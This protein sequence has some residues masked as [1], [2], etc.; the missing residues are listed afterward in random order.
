MVPAIANGLVLQWTCARLPF[1]L[2]HLQ[3]HRRPGEDAVQ[4][5]Q[6]RSRGGPRPARRVRFADDVGHVADIAGEG[7]AAAAARCGGGRGRALPAA[8]GRGRGR[9]IPDHVAHPERW[10]VYALDAPLL[11][12]GGDGC[13]GADDEQ[14]AAV[15][16]AGAA[17]AALRAAV[18]PSDAE[19]P[20]APPAALPAAGSIIF[21]PT[22][23]TTP[24]SAGIPAPGALKQQRQQRARGAFADA[25]EDEDDRAAQLGSCSDAAGSVTGGVPQR[26]AVARRDAARRQMRP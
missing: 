18:P 5:Q 24:R 2:D 9:A 22:G 21:A 4:Q 6:Q 16:E 7:T 15:R 26:A 14:G 20:S 10:T 23:K 17:A 12:G 13:G 11:V 3:C 8:P 19:Q 1:H 25:E